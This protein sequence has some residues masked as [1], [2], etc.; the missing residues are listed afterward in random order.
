MKRY[1]QPRDAAA[2]RGSAL[3]FRA[4]LPAALVLA[5]LTGCSASDAD[6]ALDAATTQ[7]DAV[8]DTN[9]GFDVADTGAPDVGTPDTPDDTSGGQPFACDGPPGSTGCAC[10]G[11]EDCDEGLCIETPDGK[12]CT[13]ACISTCP[14]PEGYE[15]KCAQVS[16]GAGSDTIQMCVPRWGRICEPCQE[17]EHCATALGS[18]D[19]VC[20]AYGEAEGSFCGAGCA[21]DEDCPA[22]YSCADATSVEGQTRKQCVLDGAAEGTA[23]C[24]C[25]L[26]ATSL[27]LTTSC[28]LT[29]D[30]GTCPGERSCGADGLSACAAPAGGEEICDGLDNDCDGVVDDTICDDGKPCTDDLCDAETGTCSHAFNTAPCS[31]GNACTEADTCADGIC[32]G[33][34]VDC[35]DDNTCTT[36]ACDPASGCA[37]TPQP[38]KKCEDGNLCTTGDS[39]AGSA[40]VGLPIAASVDCDDA[41]PCTADTCKPDEGCVNAPAPGPCDDGNPCTNGDACNA[42][43]CEPGENL[44]TCQ[45]TADCAGSEDGNA[46]N[47]TLYCDKASAPFVCKVDPNTI[48]SCDTSG[49][50]TCN[51]TVCN[52]DTG[53]CESDPAPASTPCDADGSVCT[54]ADSCSGDG[55]CLPDPLTL[56]CDDG[57]AC[58][59]NGC[60][61]AK[62]CQTVNKVG[63]CEDGDPCTAGDTC[64]TGQCV[65]GKKKD[66]ED[67]SPCTIDFC[68]AKSGQCVND[69]TQLEGAPC[70][71]DG[72]V[73]TVDDVCAAGVCTAGPPLDCEDGN[74]CTTDFCNPAA[75]GCNSFNNSEA[76]DADGDPCTVADACKNATCVAGAAKDCD[77]NNDCTLDTC[78][79]ADGSCQHETA[80]LDGKA[81]DADGSVCTEKDTCDGGVCLADPVTVDCDDGNSCT[82]DTCKPAAGCTY[83]NLSGD[84][85]SDG[86]PCTKAD[87]CIGGQCKGLQLNCTDGNPCTDDICDAVKGCVF[88]NVVD[89]T[90]C[91]ASDVCVGGAC[92]LKGCGDGFVEGDEVCDDGN[93][94]V[95]DGCE[96][97]QQRGHLVLPGDA[98]AVLPAA[99]AGDNAEPLGLEHDLTIEA[100]VKPDLILPDM[101]L[102]ARGDSAQGTAW[103]VGIT[104]GNGV[105]AFRHDGPAGAETVV[106]TTQLKAGTWQHVAVVVAGSK[107]RFFVDG[108]LGGVKPI[109]KV[110]RDVPG[111]GLTVGRRW[112]DS[113][114]EGKFFGAI[115][116]LRISNLARYGGTFV[117]RRRLTAEPGTVALYQFDEMAG[118]TLLDAGPF[119]YDLTLTKGAFG[120]D[121]C[122]G[123]A[124]QTPVCGDGQVAAGF[125]VCDDGNETLCDG[126]ESCSGSKAWDTNDTGYAFTDPFNSW[127][128]DTVCPTCDATF[129]A[130]VKL[131]KTAAVAE[132]MGTSCGYMSVNVAQGK[133]NVYRFPEPLCAGTT[134]VK[135]NT[136][137]HVAA[138]MSW[139]KGGYV[140]LY[141]NGK[142]ECELQAVNALVP[143]FTVEAL[144]IG[145]G[146][147]GVGSGCL[148]DGDAPVFGNVWPGVIDEVRVSKGQRYQHDFVPARHPLPDGQTRGLWHF[149]QT[150]A[151]GL[152]DGGQDVVTTVTGGA[153]I[154]DSCFGEPEAAASCGDAQVAK[155][156]SCDSGALNGAYPAQCSGE[157]TLN[158]TPDCTAI[159]TNVSQATLAQNSMVYPTRF[160]IEGWSKLDAYP[161]Q[162]TWGAILGTDDTFACPVPGGA[163]SWAV[164]VDSEGNDVSYLGGDNEVGTPT[165]K[166]WKLGVWQH[167]ALQYEDLGHASLYVDGH[168]VRRFTGVAEDW[169]ATCPLHV[170]GVFINLA[171]QGVAGSVSTVRISDKVRYG[172]PFVPDPSLFADGDTVRFWDFQEGVGAESADFLLGIKMKLQGAQWVTN[173]GPSC[174]P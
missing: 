45:T 144:S 98:W 129:E 122:Y 91:G 138:T 11:P 13:V 57:N 132:I 7:P 101:P 9:G 67:A 169:S 87:L 60:D 52:P 28:E 121:D 119:G 73:C 145:A 77:D 30:D 80:P 167:W 172:A 126:C 61:V 65:P 21:V 113:D 158:T 27:G 128:A 97:C 111:I 16:F 100:W 12:K 6:E 95:C 2:P 32:A 116:G 114:A 92:L 47:G 1:R 86:D 62:G 134:V 163:Q 106:G 72:S 135:P 25:S 5:A 74:V 3:G 4:L 29:T 125:E 40:C 104:P 165:S 123:G 82:T 70:D 14:V 33:V 161:P 22:G 109:G 56:D 64:A 19:A 81:C 153:L 43:A 48:V 63:P 41:N 148:A 79:P 78:D 146:A 50:T 142:Q 44:C 68:D 75:G 10:Q 160:T 149:D 23:S 34:T 37:Y 69:G 102:V 51:K 157:C 99:P 107:V 42:G 162:G 83:A 89:G 164:A 115:D 131:D 85:C 127:A 171:V 133:F 15:L 76:C 139:R 143:G 166:V 39:C 159:K 105:L 103:E 66:C 150:G 130:W 170:G 94:L 36:E 156:E 136:W 35:D 84:P 24:P 31:D 18:D 141:V 20:V 140:R 174:A 53:A 120:A 154:A 71:A 155:W 26:R 110:R 147:G 151:P 59:Q 152:D 117:P 46:C 55:A 93:D 38:G 118:Q 54:P 168:E 112:T 96:G 88:E 49:D 17:S 90:S 137:Y 8:L 58:T 108:A 173:D 124:A